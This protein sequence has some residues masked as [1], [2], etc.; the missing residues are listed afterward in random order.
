[1]SAI[2]GLFVFLYLV[3][4]TRDLAALDI[5]GIVAAKVQVSTLLFGFVVCCHAKAVL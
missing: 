3:K 5:H 4:T 2:T 1:M